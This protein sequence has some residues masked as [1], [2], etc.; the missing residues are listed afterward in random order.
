MGISTYLANALL[1]HVLRG[2]VYTPPTTLHISFHS[3]NPGKTG[4]YELT[5]SAYARITATFD[6]AAA[7]TTQTATE[8]ESAM[9]TPS[10]WSEATHFGVWDAASG[11]NF[12]MFGALTSPI[13]V[14]INYEAL[15]PDG[16][17]SVTMA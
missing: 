17:I 4:V 12:L 6:A 8:L 1:D 16:S 14:L 10:N 9:A 3:A 15:F 2:V 5:G 11:G 13:T 7:E